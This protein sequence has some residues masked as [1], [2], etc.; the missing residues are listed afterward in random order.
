MEGKIYIGEY[1][2]NDGRLGERAALGL[3]QNLSKKG[4]ETARLKTGTP[5]RVLRSS[6]DF[7]KMEEQE[8]DEIMKPFSFQSMEVMRPYAACYVTHTNE[9][10]H[11]IIR[12]AFDRSPLFSGKIK[13]IG[14]RYCPSIED[15]V[16]KFP[17]RTRHHLYIEPEGLGTE[18]LYIN[19]LS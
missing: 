7:S 2:S 13:A 17:E 18:E 5:M 14:A 3:G 11:E 1:E 16:K 6:I 15:K 8:A 9:K 12:A 10:T 4:F 19:G